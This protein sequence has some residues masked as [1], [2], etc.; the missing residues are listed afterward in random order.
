M[1]YLNAQVS[2]FMTTYSVEKFAEL[3]PPPKEAFRSKL[4]GEE[5]T[6]ENYEHVKTVWKEL[7]I[8]KLGR[9][10]VGINVSLN[11]CAVPG[12]S[13]LLYP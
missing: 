5:I 13:F 9:D 2:I 1:T 12:P 4:N 11:F 3:S 10:C 8:K 6:D 7:K